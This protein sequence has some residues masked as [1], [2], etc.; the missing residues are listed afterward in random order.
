ML[1][2]FCDI[3]VLGTELP[4]LVTAAF[5]A[6]RGLSVQ[7]VDSD[8]FTANERQP[9]PACFCNLHSKLLRSILGRLNIPEVSIQSFLN[10]ESTLQV[11][12]PKHRV[13]IFNNPLTY[14]EEIEREFP[15]HY[16][17]IKSFYEAQ[18]KLRH[19]TDV[20]ELFQQL[21]PSS[22]K[23]RRVF[24]K[25]VAEQGLSEISNE[26]AHLISSDDE[27]KHFFQAQF[28][29]AFQQR[30]DKPFKF[31]VSELLNPGDGEIYSVRAGMK[32]LKKM[33]FER[34]QHYDGGIR[35]R[36][37]INKL[38]FRSGVFEGVELDNNQGQI[39]SKYVIWNDSMPK[40]A[41]LL[42]SKW[43]F[44]K[45]R[46]YCRQLT[47]DCHWFTARFTIPKQMLP[48]P[49]K[50]NVVTIMDPSQSQMDG[51][52]LYL[53]IRTDDKTPTVA[54]IDASFIMANEALTEG[55]EFFTPYFERIRQHLN[56]LIPFAEKQLKL[57]FPLR[58]SDA[59]SDTLF[60]MSEDDLE[61]FRH[62]ARKNAISTQT[63]ESFHK[64]FPLHY[65]TVTPNFYITHPSIFAPFGIESKFVLGLK[66]TDLIWQEAE[67]IKKRAMKSERRIA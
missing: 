65:K 8:L 32:E 48:E 55:Y 66:I 61:I 22:W 67:K 18:A 21:I 9:D 3:L 39:I 28:L 17:N 31:Q 2:K 63:Q 1:E 30:I 5:L 42:P 29:L 53:Q 59:P 40:L 49:L 38:L 25:F 58:N 14:F 37:Q 4:G 27:I 64:L 19:Q 52:L 24:K 62:S 20:G 54:R 57:E 45:L 34:L 13:D 33:L 6:R 23:E 11:I 47:P 35:D 56:V 12:F 7:V 51:N 60:P 26:F 36:V 50:S 16:A 15:Q 43:R 10:Q 44:R 41:D 46:K